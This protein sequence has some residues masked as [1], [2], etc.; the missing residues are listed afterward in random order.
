MTDF[1]NLAAK[2]VAK[3]SGLKLSEVKKII[4][5]PP[6]SKLGDFSFPC[7]SIAKRQKPGNVAYNIR[8]KLSV[9]RV[10]KKVEVMGPYLNFFLNERVL[11]ETVIGEIS[12]Q[13]NKY[14]STNIGKGSKILIEHTSINPNASPHVGRSRNAIIGNSLVKLYQFQGYK[15]TVHYFVND[16]GKQIA[17]L[18]MAAGNRNPKFNELLELYVKINNKIKKNPELE[19]QVF[20]LLFKL[21]NGDPKIRKRFS[22]IV[23]TSVKGQT[24]IIAR[25][26]I[27]YDVFDYESEYL[28]NQKT[29]S[30]LR[31]LNKTNKVF[32]DE[33]SRNVLN[34]EGYNLPMKNPVFVLTR[35]DGTSLYGL[36]DIAYTIDKMNKS[37]SNL[38]VLGEDQKLYHQQ[39]CAAM[40]ILNKPAPEVV[41]YSFVLSKAGKMSTRKGDVI[42]LDDF[43]NQVY[44]KT[45][46]EIKRRKRG[47]LR[48]ASLIG[49]SAVIYSLLKVSPEK[50]VTF[51]MDSSVRFDGDTGPYLQYTH[52]RINSLAKKSKTRPSLN[53]EILTESEIELIKKLN[54]FS[55]NVTKAFELRKPSI[56][57]NYAMELSKL[58]NS[59]YSQ[60]RII[61][62][63]K[64]NTAHRMSISSAT[65]QVLANSLRLM[66]IEPVDEM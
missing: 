46:A 59:F 12:K 26:G 61:S 40:N 45:R 58:Y 14:G 25:L 63:D 38:I 1:L 55:A 60:N 10:F 53:S 32:V 21:E 19:K 36:R 4:E 11:A 52:A 27:T 31:K 43:I 47:K 16:V 20:D 57:A 18:V 15:P 39:I 41:H 22:K 49:N 7:F 23:K 44:S 62:I 30:V 42:L 48:N 33:G 28:F 66:G 37:K 24:D 17:M 51:D 50:N 54:Q 5:I 29:N 64:K 34:L 9:P 2:S 65:R 56:V 6:N 13:K 3:A 35:G 8:K